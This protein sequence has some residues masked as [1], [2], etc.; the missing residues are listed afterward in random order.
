[1]LGGPGESMHGLEGTSLLFIGAVLLALLV[2]G[3]WL[4][5]LHQPEQDDP[6]LKAA[7][8]LPPE[9]RERALIRWMLY[10]GPRRHPPTDSPRQ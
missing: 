4:G 5:T 9:K 2:L 8:E 6:E 10:I 3:R 1:M 7:L